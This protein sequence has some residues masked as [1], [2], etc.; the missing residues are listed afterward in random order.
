[1]HTLFEKWVQFNRS[2]TMMKKKTVNVLRL[3]NK[4]KNE[5]IKLKRKPK[6]GLLRD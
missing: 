5:L 2:A 6:K 3:E 4:K 1:M